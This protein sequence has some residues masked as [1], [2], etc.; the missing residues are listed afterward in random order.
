[1]GDTVLRVE[2]LEN[3][4]TVEVCDEKIMEENRKPKSEYQDPWKA[5]AFEDVEGVVQFVKDCLGK[6][7]PP[8]DAESEYAQTFK[9]ASK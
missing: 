5:Y 2:K 8:P 9:A 6:L 3:G 1:M 4:Y 7:K